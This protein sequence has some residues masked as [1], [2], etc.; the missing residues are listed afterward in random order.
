MF[1]GSLNPDEATRAAAAS[2][3]RGGRVIDPANN[4]DSPFDIV[5]RD[6]KVSELLPPGAPSDART[7][8]VAG[9]IVSPGFVDL[10]GHWYEG[11]PWGIDPAINLRSGVT[12]PCDAGTTG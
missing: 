12:T 6:G 3:L 1:D 9:A 2:V 11:S 4:V 10:H 7:E 5:V 8:S